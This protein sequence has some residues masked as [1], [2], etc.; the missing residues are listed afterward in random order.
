M[1]DSAPTISVLITTFNRSRLL[2]RAIN[3][4]LIQDYDDFELIIIDDCSTD[5]TPAV[6]A[7]ISDPRIRYIRNEVNVG[8]KEGDRAHMRRF[9]YELMRGTY[10]VYLCDDD[11][12]LM[13]DLLRRQVAAFDIYDNVVMVM[14][15]QLSYFLTTPDSYFGRSP[16]DTL[17]FTLEN[18]G[19]YFDLDTLTSKTPHLHF[20][21]GRAGKSLFTKSW[22]T[23][24]EFLEEFSGEPAAKNIIGGAM[25]YSREL[26]IKAGGFAAPTGSQW[27]AGYELKMG[28]ACY[29]Q[30]VYLNEPSIVTEIRDSN[31]SFR[32]TQVEHYLDSIVS[33]EV[34][35]AVP[36]ASDELLPKRRFLQRI[37]AKTIRNLSRAFLSNTVTV[38]R[39]GS[40]GMCSEDNLST[41]V[42]YRHVLPVL[43][44]NGALHMLRWRDLKF[45]IASAL[46]ARL[47]KALD[48]KSLATKG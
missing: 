40:L 13:P 33:I 36:L 21:R 2:R 15:G 29:G 17:T 12:W 9:V 24:E 6:V 18:L 48:A 23:S 30:T 41:P 31:A 44:H 1:S 5:D 14:G 28:P 32:G 35:F 7:S 16:D 10:F 3:S 27:Q 42:T 22:M 38:R 26:F 47:F 20:M 19:D 25:L 37:R 43:A 11:Y 4:V 46:P 39:Y 8:S 45:L 34:A